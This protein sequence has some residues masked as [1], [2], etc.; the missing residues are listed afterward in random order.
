MSCCVWLPPSPHPHAEPQISSDFL[1]L[2][3]EVISKVYD[4]LAEKQG[5]TAEGVA[6]S[7][8]LLLLCYPPGALPWKLPCSAS[9]SWGCFRVLEIVQILLIYLESL[10]DQSPSISL[11]K[12]GEYASFHFN[13][14]LTQMGTAPVW[15]GNWCH[16]Y[17]QK[18]IL[19]YRPFFSMMNAL[20]ARGLGQEINLSNRYR[21]VVRIVPYSPQSPIFLFP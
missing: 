14:T 17:I 21:A 20:G 10:V 6:H 16:T 12:C 7:S 13:I 5:Q 4:T 8:V 19:T 15:L 2:L 1:Q 3:M 11:S 9:H 18:A